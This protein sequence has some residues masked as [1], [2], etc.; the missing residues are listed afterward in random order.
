MQGCIGATRQ[1][2][3]GEGE[4]SSPHTL[5]RG[6][7]EAASC[8]HAGVASS[9]WSG[10]RFSSL[11]E[12]LRRQISCWTLSPQVRE[13]SYCIRR[14]REKESETCRLLHAVTALKDKD[15]GKARMRYPDFSE[16]ESGLQFKDFR[17][18]T[19]EQPKDGG[20]SR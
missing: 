4:E 1:V 16:T 15:Y 19:G 10:A 12:R 6:P 8:M 18:G 7:A 2:I 11:L 20:K 13:P 17:L 14:V 3:P 9:P 5:F